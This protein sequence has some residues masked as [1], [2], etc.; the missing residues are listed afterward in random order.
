MSGREESEFLRGDIGVDGQ[1]VE[2]EKDEAEVQRG[3]AV[4]ALA[5]GR[6]YLGREFLTWLLW[7]SNSGV[8]ITQHEG[9]DLSLLVVGQVI[10][11][12]LAGD[13]TELAVKGHLSAYSDVVRSAIDKGLL[14]HQAR[15]RIQFGEQVYEVTLDAEHLDFKGAQ[16]PKVL[17][18]EDADQI[19]ERLF[20][21][22][23]LAGLVDALWGAFMEVRASG[24]WK[25]KA[26]PGIKRWVSEAG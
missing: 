12:G 23:R 16:I 5:R 8:T 11:R 9:E 2:E 4:E 14:V 15:L 13:A 21:C 3:E 24:E 18:E 22:E 17:S 19:T 1:A 26:V 25:K 7:M 20:L 6:A 10:L